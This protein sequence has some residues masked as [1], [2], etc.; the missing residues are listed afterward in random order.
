MEV[1]NKM[2]ESSKNDVIYTNLINVSLSQFDIALDVCYREGNKVQSQT[3]VVMSPQHF[4]A[5]VHM[6]MNNL[7]QYEELFGAI[8]LE[9]N[10]EVLHRLKDQGIVK[11]EEVPNARRK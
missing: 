8:N 2:S 9:A 11:I 1:D 3:K 7:K 6:L 5:L 4:K 10:Q